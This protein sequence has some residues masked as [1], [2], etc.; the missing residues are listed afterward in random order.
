MIGGLEIYGTLVINNE[1][2]FQIGAACNFSETLIDRLWKS[3]GLLPIARQ[4]V[5]E[6]FGELARSEG[7]QFPTRILTDSESANCFLGWMFHGNPGEVRLSWF[8]EQIQIYAEAKG[9]AFP[10]P[11]RS[12][13]CLEIW[14]PLK[15]ARADPWS[16]IGT[17][18][19]SKWGRRTCCFAVRCELPAAPCW[20]S[21]I[22][23]LPKRDQVLQA[24]VIWVLQRFMA[25]WPCF[26][27]SSWCLALAATPSKHVRCFFSNE[28][29]ELS[30]SMTHCIT[31]ERRHSCE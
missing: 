24:R 13:G 19:C 28:S 29:C 5:A 7:R 16:P 4:I 18:N 11:C 10:S 26:D 1:W 20:T 23:P 15:E 27:S 22:E 21:S 14:A 6:F 31:T 2:I 25:S 3:G 17:C 12:A 9:P 30:R 8:R